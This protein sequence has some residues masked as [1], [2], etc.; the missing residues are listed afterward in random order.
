MLIDFI[1][2]NRYEL[3]RRTGDR[4]RARSAPHAS[5]DETER[6]VPLFLTQFIALLETTN[7]DRPPTPAID[8]SASTHGNDLFKRGFTIGQLVH[9]YG[10]ICQAIT[11]LAGEQATQF[12][13]KEFHLLNLCLDNA[14]ANAV[15]E[16]SRL[17]D[18][19]LDERS[20]VSASSL[21][22]GGD[23]RPH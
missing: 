8:A 3:I 14:I 7:S 13:V 5:P 18:Q 11:E 22:T 4:M 1:K 19:D 21:T 10:D 16:Y 23:L 9:G 20:S 2:K 17:Q 15:T 6:G 12:S